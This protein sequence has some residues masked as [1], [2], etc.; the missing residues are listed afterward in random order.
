MKRY[1]IAVL[2]RALALAVSLPLL[3]AG[4]KQEI[5]PVVNT[6]YLP[7]LLGLIDRAQ[8]GIDFIQLEWQY[9]PDV[10]KVQDHLRGA[11][12]R[13]VRVRGLLE[14]K[15]RFNATSAEF[16]T[17]YGVQTKLDTTKKMTHN[18][19]FVA[20]G[21]EVL[22]GSTNLT[23]NSMERN[24]ETNVLIRDEAIGRFFEGYFEKLWEDSEKEPALKPFTSGAVT[25]FTNRAYLK[26]IL[27]L[28]LGAKSSIRVLM[29]GVN[30]SP[31]DPESAATRLV[32]ALAAAAAR[33]VKVQVLLDKSDYNDGINEV[34][35]RAKAYLESKGVAVRYDDEEV[36]SHAKLICVDDAAVVGSYNWGYDALE[37]RNEC[38]VIIRDKATSEFFRKYF[39]ILWEGKRW[40]S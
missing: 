18:K 16:L 11:M 28:L 23:Q 30:C 1:G 15:I 35:K 8:K 5:V 34:N 25:A 40:V 26:E 31:D 38:A 27:P 22:L 32:D 2:Y 7:A 21:R 4:E 20:D 17:K 39:D 12:K 10:K 14:N 29:Y 9:R 24:N 19:L 6:G 3:A 33:G 37:R 13:G 36:T